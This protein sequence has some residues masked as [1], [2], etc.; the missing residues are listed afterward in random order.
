MNDKTRKRIVYGAGITGVV[1][2][3]IAFFLPSLARVKG[4]PGPNYRTRSL[5]KDLSV[6][7]EIYKEKFGDFPHGNNRDVVRILSGDNSR[8]AQ[9]LSLGNRF[10]NHSGEAIDG[11][12]TPLQ[13]EIL[14][15]N[16][17]MVRSAGPNKKF[18][19]GDDIV[20]G[21]Y[22]VTPSLVTTNR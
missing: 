16:T 20:E 21:D 4:G 14:R 22:V 2:I 19:D 8:K 7:M 1:I 9:Y 18:G 3:G 17:P 15:T 11:W 13:I 10:T 5:A 6:C 12:G